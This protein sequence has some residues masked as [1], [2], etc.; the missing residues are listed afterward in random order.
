MD[1][2]IKV[3][4][5]VKLASCEKVGHL[6]SYGTRPEPLAKILSLNNLW[7]SVTINVMSAQWKGSH[8]SKE[9][10]SKEL[11][12]NSSLPV[13]QEAVSSK[14]KIGQARIPQL[15]P[16]SRVR[17]WGWRVTSRGRCREMIQSRYLRHSHSFC[18]RLSQEASSKGRQRVICVNRS[19]LWENGNG[20]PVHVSQSAQGLPASVPG[21]F[22]HTPTRALLSLPN[23]EINSENVPM[24]F[25]V[26]PECH[27]VM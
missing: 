17:S 1:K 25:Y 7:I 18:A 2:G 21:K 4:A 15:S 3:S 22:S 8:S 19:D 26:S 27:R 24:A 20:A 6:G 13:G 14:H 12:I 16:A 10:I 11:V 5:S 23:E 9:D